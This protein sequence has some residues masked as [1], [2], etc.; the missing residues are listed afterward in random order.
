MKIAKCHL[1]SISPYS[2][3]RRLPEKTDK[4][5]SY[6]D[7]ENEVWRQRMH[8]NDEGRVFVPPMCFK[9]SLET[10]ARFLREKIPGKGNSE[11]AK[12]FK[13]GVLVVEG[14]VLPIRRED[15]QFERLP[16]SSSGKPGGMDVFKNMPVIPQWEGDVDFHVLDD[17]ITKDVFER[18]LKE[19]GSFIGLGRFRPE[20]GGYYGRYEVVS[21][22]WKE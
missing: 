3:S 6:D 17:T 19:A 4:K 20:K 15:A 12:H 16:L 14:L 2:Q 21:I 7:W 9:R 13:A 18:T 5:Q 10:A 11:Y 1:K 22:T 8:V